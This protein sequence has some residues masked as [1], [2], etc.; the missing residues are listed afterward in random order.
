MH[1][2]ESVSRSA[3]GGTR[4]APRGRE[5]QPRVNARSA[6][7]A[8]GLRDGCLRGT[9]PAPRGRDPPVR[10]SRVPRASS[11]TPRASLPRTPPAVPPPYPRRMT[12][13]AAR[14]PA[15]QIQTL[16]AL[17]PSRPRPSSPCSPKPP[18][19]T[20]CRPCPS[21]AGSSCAA[22]TARAY[23]TS[24]SPRTTS[25]PGTDSWRTPTPS[26]LPPPSCVVHPAR[27]GRGHGRALGVAL[28]HASGKR[29][30]AWAHGGKSAAR[31]LAQVLGL[32]LFRELRQLRR[33][34]T[35]PDIPEPVS[36]PGSPSV[37]S[38]PGR[39]TRPGSR[40]TPPPSPTT[41]SRAR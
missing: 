35:P 5:R 14:E 1:G 7:G 21:R 37:R 29:L 6:T 41:P 11:R 26:R 27:R 3:G 2:R 4:L 39:T 12:D 36:P 32:T 24:C 40:S 34:L 38:Y 31:H 20:A 28:L 8:R 18:P 15:R 10:P 23:G 22:D 16:D 13:A 19:R 25:S 33:P 17:T 9:R 30:R